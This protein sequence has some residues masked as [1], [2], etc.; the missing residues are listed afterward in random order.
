MTHLMRGLAAGAAGTTALNATTYLDMASRGRPAST[1]PEET[2]RSVERV[3]DTS[4]GSEADESTGENR[5]SGVGALLGIGS[6]LAA[7][8]LHS[9]LRDRLPRAPTPLL[10]LGTAA[11]AN[12]GTVAPMAA[13]GVTRPRAWPASSWVADLVPHLVFGVV[14]AACYDLL[15]RRDEHPRT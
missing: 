7:G 2:V 4:L 14:T 12:A 1:T 5:R 9:L 11:A 15:G 13:L 10:A 6:G 8:L 3:A